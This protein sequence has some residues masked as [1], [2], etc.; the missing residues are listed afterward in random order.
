VDVT[1]RPGARRRSAPAETALALHAVELGWKL[2]G[3]ATPAQQVFR[4]RAAAP[5]ILAEMV[6][7]VDAAAGMKW[8]LARLH[9]GDVRRSSPEIVVTA[10]FARRLEAAI[11]A[12]TR[13][14]LGRRQAAGV[15][16]GRQPLIPDGI[17]AQI[18]RDRSAGM[19]YRR[20]AA[21]LQAAGVPT[22]Q[23]GREWRASTV[24]AAYLRATQAP[25]D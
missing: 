5:T 6:T 22:A 24:R 7:L 18:V 15:R 23:G 21:G 11:G 1:A 9:L 17:L 4:R 16:L 12:A 10:T 25:D 14:A 20:I 13:E 3:G 19:S 8:A 2:A